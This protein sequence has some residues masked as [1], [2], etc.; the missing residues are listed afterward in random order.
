MAV[1][2]SGPAREATQVVVTGHGGP[3]RLR[4][5]SVPVPQPGPGELRVAVRGAGVNFADILIRQGV[6]PGAPQPP[7]VIGHEIAGVVDSVG[8]D[9]DPIWVGREVIALTDY[10]GYSTHHVL[11]ANRALLKPEGISFADAAALPLNY[12]TAWVLLV[13]M[14]SL[15]SDQTLLIQNAGGGVG[16]AAIDIARHIGARI[17]GT[18]SPGKHEFLT[19]RGVDH[20]VDYRRADWPGEVTELTRGR[21]VDLIID[22]LG[23]ASWRRSLALLAPAGRLGMFGVS[24]AAAPGLRG[25]LGLAAAMIRAPLLHPARLIRGN[26]GVFGCNIH[27][28]YSS[29]AKLNTWL[30][31]ILRGVNQGWARP[32]VDRVFALDEASLA[33]E[34]IEARRN[35]GKVILTPLPSPP[36]GRDP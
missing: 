28:M 25:K 29:R 33:H 34:H 13:V 14:G 30:G 9:V 2:S 19:E 6:Y 32:H 1:P 8:D 12:V 18:S 4:V 3:D 31:E 23:P 11:D 24:E 15:R 26:R 21:G 7:C 36:G 17:L 5:R 10:G 16:L 35:I 20:P 27:Q 22:P